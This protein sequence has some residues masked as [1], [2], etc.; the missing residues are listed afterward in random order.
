MKADAP[1]EKGEMVYYTPNGT[2][3]PYRTYNR[4]ERLIRWVGRILGVHQAR[5]YHERYPIGIALHAA[6]KGC[7]TR[8]IVRGYIKDGA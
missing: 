1:I 6:D 4:R 8:V 2:V 3:R 5:R 7:T